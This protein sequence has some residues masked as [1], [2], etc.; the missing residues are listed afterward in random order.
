MDPVDLLCP[1]LK[2]PMWDAVVTKRGQIYSERGILRHIESQ[3]TA[4]DP[5][6]REPLVRDE[7]S[8]ALWI[9]EAASMIAPTSSGW[10]SQIPIEDLQFFNDIDLS[11]LCKMISNGTKIT[12]FQL[13]HSLKYNN[14][15]FPVLHHL[16][17]SNSQTLLEEF[18]NSDLLDNYPFL[19]PLASV[20]IG[21]S[22]PKI[23][24][25]FLPSRKTLSQRLRKVL[26]GEQFEIA[27]QNKTVTKLLQDRDF[28]TLEK[29]AH[30]NKVPELWQILSRLN[31]EK[32]GR[33][34]QLW[35]AIGRP[36]DEQ[37]CVSCPSDVL[38]AEEKLGIVPPDQILRLTGG[39]H[40]CFLEA[41]A[42][43]R[44]K[45]QAWRIIRLID[46]SF[47]DPGIGSLLHVLTEVRFDFD[48]EWFV[49]KRIKVNYQIRNSMGSTFVELDP[50]RFI[51]YSFFRKFIR[52]LPDRFWETAPDE[53]VKSEVLE[54]GCFVSVFP[55]ALKRTT[56]N[57]A[58]FLDQA[59]EIKSRELLFKSCKCLG[60][61][62]LLSEYR[63][64]G[65]GI[66]HYIVRNYPRHSTLVSL[67]QNNY[68]DEKNDKGETVA[69]ILQQ[70]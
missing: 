45:E 13:K 44:D 57:F 64:N 11:I 65:D 36:T 35:D 28:D 17:K 39:S 59:A 22:E 43:V 31:T 51:S 70:K 14:G 29:V 7:L 68:L 15:P 63:F 2:V 3:S 37:L 62:Q 9:R 6:T 27:Q 16:C 69:D 60:D 40:R 38:F 23:A 4:R 66:S 32:C 46:Q 58:V 52:I 26:G 19:D 50:D 42:E 30:K 10:D 49:D 67:V 20:S 12:I 53:H 54:R 24:I 41:L 21:G 18:I 34:Y 8:P 5:L 47:V 48:W 33:A 56:L 25:A 1:I 61:L 55:H